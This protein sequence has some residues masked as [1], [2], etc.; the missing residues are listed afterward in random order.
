M[1]MALP[2]RPI[3]GAT[4][5]TRQGMRFPGD[6]ADRSTEEVGADMELT[7]TG[8][9]ITARF[10]TVRKEMGHPW[11]TRH[12]GFQPPINYP[13]NVKRVLN[14]RTRSAIG[15]FFKSRIRRRRGPNTSARV[16]RLL[17]TA[18]RS[19]KLSA[20]GSICRL[21][22]IR[23]VRPNQCSDGDLHDQIDHQQ[24]MHYLK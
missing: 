11:P 3:M 6:S 8:V 16:H 23:H 1:Y 14:C 7:A 17:P 9:S 13:C 4:Q 24:W 22:N 12:M 5:A 15:S 21:R 20:R 18:R 10:A 19:G 2:P